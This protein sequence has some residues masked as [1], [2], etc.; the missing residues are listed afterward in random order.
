MI[1][2]WFI[3]AVVSLILSGCGKKKEQVTPAEEKITESVY[4]SGAVKSRNQYQVYAS[5]NGVISQVLVN[6][7]DRVKKG[8]ALMRI[9]NTTAQ[10]NLEN[11]RITADYSS[12]SANSEKLQELATNTELAR[13]KMNSEASLLERQKNLWEQQIG[14]R[15]D[16]EQRELA[17]KSAVATYNAAK[18]RYAQLQK[19]VSFQEKQ[20]QKNLQ[21]SRAATGDF[22]VRSEVSGKVYSILKK[23]GEMAAIQ[24]PVAIVGEEN[25]FML[26]LQ[27][28]EYDI[29][30]IQTGQKILVSM[31][32]YKGKVFEARVEQVNPLMNERT[33][34]F[35]IDAVFT[36]PPPTLY[37][38]LTC[39]ANIII[40][41][42]EKALV[43]P[44]NCL[45][46]GDYVI[47]ASKEKRK[48]T[49]GLKDLQKA[50]ILEGIT[51]KDVLLKPE[52]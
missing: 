19:Q 16:L 34:T 8:D 49:V 24:T 48:V 6:E 4:A 21:I 45:L 18:L 43:I 9:T 35:I 20:S 40:S 39:E 44:R 30:K 11:A 5:V 33:K 7:G 52:Q 50:E 38:N 22:T 17:Y 32:S 2:K 46:E 41:E 14:S 47:L 25:A 31:D 15:N 28:D 10:L 3:I 51:I 12:V 23:K 36:Q 13:I 27:V 1:A 26:E 37:P 29:A 42:K